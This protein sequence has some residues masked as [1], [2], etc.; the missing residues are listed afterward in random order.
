MMTLQ[1][2]SQAWL[3]AKAVEKSAQDQRRH[4]EDKLLS[5]LGTAEN[6]DGTETHTPDGYRV[7]VTGRINRKVDS[8]R[9]QEIARE[10]GIS[11]QLGVLF[12]W[13][14]EINTAVWKATSDNITNVLSEAVTATPGRPS[15]SIE[16]E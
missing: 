10:N 6:L 8:A 12:R 11:D 4:I 1:E 15:I 2:L 13:K 3:D 5:A 16:K 7:K 14:P 9:L